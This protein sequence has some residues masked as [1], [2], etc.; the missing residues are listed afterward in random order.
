MKF[1][2]KRMKQY[3]SRYNYYT[4]RFQVGWQIWKF[5]ENGN[6]SKMTI[7]EQFQTFL[8]FHLNLITTN[9]IHHHPPPFHK[10]DLLL[11]LFN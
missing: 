2:F 9:F 1:T 10:I 5:L 3:L 8:F 7:N 11:N 6:A 4:Y